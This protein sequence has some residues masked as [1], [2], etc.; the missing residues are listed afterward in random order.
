MRH[1]GQRV[2]QILARRFGSAD[3][4][5]LASE[6]ELSSTDEIGPVIAKSVFDYCH[7]ED[8]LHVFKQL[9]EAGVSLE[10]STDDAVDHAGV[11]AGKSIVVTGTL[12]RFSR[13]E[14]ERLIEKLGGKASSSV[15]KKTDY[16]VAGEAAGSKLEKANQLGVPVVTEEEFQTLIG[17]NV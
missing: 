4:L 2:A 7:S 14:I 15:S 17:E 9:R 6:E 11:L 12:K 3:R 1:V 13:D 8:G 5:L 16:V 10:T